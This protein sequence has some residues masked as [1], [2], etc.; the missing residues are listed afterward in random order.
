MKL[1]DWLF[2][3]FSTDINSRTEKPSDA[4]V[5]VDMGLIRLLG[6]NLTHDPK[7]LENYCF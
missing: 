2:Y 7:G 4:K 6:E 1:D 5:Y 3:P